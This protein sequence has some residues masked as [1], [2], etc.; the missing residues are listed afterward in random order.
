MSDRHRDEPIDPARVK[1]G[2]HPGQARAPVVADDVGT[3]DLQRVEDRNH[4]VGDSSYAGGL[5]LRWHVRVAEA[6]QVGHDHAVAGR[7]EYGDLVPPHVRRVGK[8]VQQ[9]DGRSVT[10]VA[11]CERNPISGLDALHELRFAQRRRCQ[12]PFESD[13]E[14]SSRRPGRRATGWERTAA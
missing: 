5:D 9:H 3:L 13:C 6:S 14:L 2:D 11:D 12:T 10:L 4:V 1:S 8:A 7:I